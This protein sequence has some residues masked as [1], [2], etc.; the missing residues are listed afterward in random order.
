VSSTTPGAEPAPT[1]FLS[2]LLGALAKSDI[3]IDLQRLRETAPAPT[4]SGM[5]EI[6][7]ELQILK[8]LALDMK[9]ALQ[10]ERKRLFDLD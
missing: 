3:A 10:A 1:Q 2:A 4:P 7:A 5:T 8:S 6:Q 9:A